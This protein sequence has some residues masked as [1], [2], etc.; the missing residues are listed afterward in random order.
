[1]CVY[2]CFVCKCV[3][4]CVCV[5]ACVCVY[6]IIVSTTCFIDLPEDL[7]HVLDN[8]LSRLEGVL[9]K[10]VKKCSLLAKV[11]WSNNH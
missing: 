4:V 10:E 6:F 8:K 5:C 2:M 9:E 3:C 7:L 11:L 1:M